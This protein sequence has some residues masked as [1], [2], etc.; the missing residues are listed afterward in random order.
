LEFMPEDTNRYELIGG[1]L[2]VSRA[3]HLDHQLLITNFI[4]AFSE[5]LKKNPIGIVVTTPG[6][7]F[8]PEDAVIPD[9]VF[10]TH[11]TVK[12]S[13]AGA[14]EKF[15]GKFTAAPEMLIE[16]LSYGKKDIERDR[17]HKREFY[18]KYGVK[19]YWVADGLFNT[20]EVYRLEEA[21]LERVKR[22]EIYETIKTPIL[23][24]YSLKL[25]DIFRN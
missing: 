12:K 5:Y 24:D 1:K 19:E 18:G 10:A 23:P 11:E 7:I 2:F 16:I 8:S 20:I 3:P 4:L 13:V 9:L 21:G 6:V 25:A 14:D 15:G 17:V 22:F